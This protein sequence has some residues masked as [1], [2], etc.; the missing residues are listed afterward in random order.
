MSPGLLHRIRRAKFLCP[1][2]LPRGREGGILADLYTHRHH[3]EP[4]ERRKR[5]M[6]AARRKTRRAHPA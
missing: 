6:D 4:S 1:S 2:Q 5:K 3:E